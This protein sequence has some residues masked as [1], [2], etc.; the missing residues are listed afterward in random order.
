MLLDRFKKVGNFLTAYFTKDKSLWARLTIEN[1]Q[2]ILEAERLLKN[3]LDLAV[4]IIS[5]VDRKSPAEV[6]LYD[7]DDLSKRY[8]EIAAE[9]KEIPKMP[10][11][12]YCKLDKKSYYIAALIEEQ[13]TAQMIEIIKFKEM[14]D[15]LDT[16]HFQIASMLREI[17]RGMIQ[18]YDADSHEQRADL[19]KKH[20]LAKDALAVGGF[21]LIVWEEYLKIIPQYLNQE[22]IDQIRMEI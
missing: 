2:D 5:I 1:L 10:L 22:M 6:K 9:L 3:P 4:T 17:K 15:N 18:D 20:F 7:Y 14:E 11:P 8:K 21:F 12:K 19:V 16:L 13:Q